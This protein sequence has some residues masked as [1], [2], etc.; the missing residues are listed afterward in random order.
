LFSSLIESNCL[1]S[2]ASA[3]TVFTLG[4]GVGLGFATGVGLVSSF[5][6]SLTSA[7]FL[8]SASAF[9]NSIIFT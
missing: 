7:S 2:L 4:F 6:S 3:L 1:L 5:I 8:G 9:C